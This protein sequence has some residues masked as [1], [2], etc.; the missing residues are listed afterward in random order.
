MCLASMTVYSITEGAAGVWKNT[1]PPGREKDSITKEFSFQH[2]QETQKKN[3]Q[4]WPTLTKRTAASHPHEHW[5][6]CPKVRNAPFVIV[7]TM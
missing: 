6:N 1:H 4:V 2:V 5:D 3:R 7:S